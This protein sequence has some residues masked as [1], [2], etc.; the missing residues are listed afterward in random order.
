MSYGAFGGRFLYMLRNACKAE[1]V[2]EFAIFRKT[3][4]DLGRQFEEPFKV[5]CGFICWIGSKIVHSHSSRSDIRH[6]IFPCRRAQVLVLPPSE[7]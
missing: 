1:P 7:W 5:F 2:Q 3:E 6:A 4:K